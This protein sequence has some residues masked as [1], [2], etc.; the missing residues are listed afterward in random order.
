MKIIRLVALCCFSFSLGSFNSLQAD[1]SGAHDV[2]VTTINNIY[3]DIAVDYDSDDAL[4]ASIE[5]SIDR[6]LTPVLDINKF[7]RLILAS[8][9]KKASVQQRQRFTEIL[10]AY[11]FRTLTKAI[12]EHRQVL[13]SYQDNI[14][15]M[16]ARSGRNENRAMVS[17]TVDTGSQSTI[18]LDFR[19]GRENG[20][21]R[22]YDVIVQDVSFAINYRAILNSE[23]KQHGIEKVAE[24]FD[25]K[26]R[27]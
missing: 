18:N 20:T 3:G 13:L 4:R 19:M 10:R 5:Q 22:A 11:L 23:I 8:H 14:D 15:V 26:L 9:W 21:W 17:V 2:V 25:T 1:V 16:K 7:T 12:L 24:S 27:E 6:H